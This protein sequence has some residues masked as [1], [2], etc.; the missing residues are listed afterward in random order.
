MTVDQMQDAQGSSA[1]RRKGGGCGIIF[2]GVRLVEEVCR[3]VISLGSA[4]QR[5]EVF[6]YLLIVV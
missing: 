5:A 3:F 1:D 4:R 6:F 2:D